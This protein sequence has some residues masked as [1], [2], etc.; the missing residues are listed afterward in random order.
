RVELAIAQSR[1]CFLAGLYRDA[2]A[3]GEEAVALAD[4]HELDEHRL[5]A[6]RGLSLVLG[7][8]EQSERLRSNAL[9]FLQLTVELGDTREEAMARNDLACSFLFAGELDAAG[10]EIERAVA[11]CTELH[12]AGRFP[13]AYVYSTRAELRIASG[14]APGAI[15]DCDASLRLASA[16]EDPEPY[17]TAMT[18][19]IKI[20]ALIACG[21]LELALT[22][23]HAELDR[24]G[25]DV[26]H[27]RSLILRT[28]AAALHEAGRTDEAFAAVH[29]S[30][31]LDRVTF[32]QLTARQLDLQRASLEAQAASHEAQVLSA[33][34]AQ[35]E[36]LVTELRRA[37]GAEEAA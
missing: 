24:L 2:L 32:E 23:A 3:H 16:A 7:N 28:I 17:L 8:V 6:R 34:N 15:A 29:A 25:D 4:R 26:P 35:L 19:H 18:T 30:A 27:A 12:A 37:Q 33:K 10:A 9:E 36:A 21:D 1:L 14:D 31:D 20:E 5:A 22:T 11:L 13:L